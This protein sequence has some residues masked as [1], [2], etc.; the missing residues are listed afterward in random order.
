LEISVEA[1]AESVDAVVD[2]FSRHVY[3]R[4]VVLNEPFVQDSD[5]DNLEIDATR[6]VVVSGYLPLNA[7]VDESVRR[8]DEGLWHLRHLGTVGELTRR[9][10]HE[11]DWANAWKEHFPI[12]RIGRRF[13]VRP[14]WREYTAQPDDV[15][16][17]IDPGM[18][19]GTG[20]HPTTA[21]CLGWL[22]AIDVRGL[23]VLD[24]GAGSGILSIAAAK[25]GA[26]SIDAIEVDPVAVSA[27]RQN[28]ALNDLNERVTIW[29]ADATKPL[30]VNGPYDLILAN[31]ISRILMATAASLAAAA[32]PETTM[33]LSGVIEAHEDEVVSTFAEYGFGVAGRRV[34]GDW[35]SLLVTR[36]SR[37]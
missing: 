16:L 30:P 37:A 17:D 26:R 23:C 27:L 34:S 11:E 32:G 6:P 18:A 8:I 25:L 5:G 28:I 1:D 36:G 24:A 31:M 33:V 22:E 12:T 2:L 19:F 14:T 29:T 35:V 9:V 13:V 3:N 20:L 15:V 7:S 21:L 10:Q 4:G